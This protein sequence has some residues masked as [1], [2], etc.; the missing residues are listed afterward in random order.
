MTNQPLNVQT[1]EQM[2]TGI[3]RGKELLSKAEGRLDGL[4]QQKETVVSQIKSLGVE[5]E[6]LDQEIQ[7]EQE[8]INALYKEVQSLIPAGL[9]NN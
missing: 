4:N 8:E 3:A 9:M 2:K 7:K 1:L 5:P 6:T